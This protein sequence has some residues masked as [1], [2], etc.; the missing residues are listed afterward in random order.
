M[1]IGYSAV[2]FSIRIAGQIALRALPDKLKHRKFHT[3]KPKSEVGSRG[4]PAL[5]DTRNGLTIECPISNKEPQNYEGRYAV[6]YKRYREAIPSLVIRH[7]T[8]DI[9]RFD[10]TSPRCRQAPALACT[11]NG[12]TGEC[13]TSNKEPQED[14]GRHT[15]FYDRYREPIP[16]LVIRHWTLDILRFDCTSALQTGLRCERYLTN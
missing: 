9:L 8:L 4:T 14:E 5:A 6:I 15:V 3:K 2:R 11:G 13:P 16:S 12:L 1:D 10:C 7:W